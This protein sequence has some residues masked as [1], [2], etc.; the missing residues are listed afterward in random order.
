MED[1]GVENFDLE[2]INEDFGSCM[3]NYSAMD[4]VEAANE[5]GL[6]G[7][8]TNFVHISEIKNYFE[9]KYFG[10]NSGENRTMEGSS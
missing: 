2:N 5:E 1:F 8:D 3:D 10:K 4:F 9:Q 6:D 7:S